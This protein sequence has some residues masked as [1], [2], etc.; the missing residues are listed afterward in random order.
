MPLILWFAFGSLWTLFLIVSTWVVGFRFLAR[1]RTER[2]ASGEDA[3]VSAAT[4]TP[5][6]QELLRRVERAVGPESHFIAYP[7]DCVIGVLDSPEQGAAAAEAFRNHGI[8]HEDVT[9]FR[10]HEGAMTIDS[11][12]RYHGLVL[13][14]IRVIEAASMDSDHAERYER[15]AEA[16]HLV[17]AVHVRNAAQRSMVE[18]VFKDHDGHF[19]NWYG[20]M[21]FEPVI[22]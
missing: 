7:T 12:G 14:L 4:P 9:V 3:A 13:R 20:R 2:Q 1:D 19:V 5:Q 6:Q 16:G 15:E 10:G 18:D 21:H 8:A 17:I 11:S 22:T